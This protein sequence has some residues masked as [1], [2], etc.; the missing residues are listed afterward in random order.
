MDITEIMCCNSLDDLKSLLCEEIIPLLGS[1]EKKLHAELKEILPVCPKKFPGKIFTLS[2]KQLKEKLTQQD[3]TIL[4][5]LYAGL[6]QYLEKDKPS[7]A[8]LLYI[9][10][11]LNQKDTSAPT[12]ARKSKT[13]SK[14]EEKDLLLLRAY[15]YI[16]K[17]RNM[18][19]H[20]CLLDYYDTLESG[21]ELW[22][23]AEA[24]AKDFE[25]RKSS[26]MLDTISKILSS[27]DFSNKVKILKKK[28]SEKA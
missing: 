16:K 6:K 15:P 13:E 18:N 20:G 10:T 22:S 26:K 12:M 4:I 23:S 25:K 7:L 19:Q 28:L 11:I 14:R 9:F 17:H 5:Q 21:Q 3:G 2:Q 8:L 24:F 27:D 1:C